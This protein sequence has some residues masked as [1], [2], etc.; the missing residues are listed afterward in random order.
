MNSIFVTGTDTE[1]GKTV[2]STALLQALTARGLSTLA[3]KPVAA[4][5]EWQTA[6]GSNGE[7][8]APR[9]CNEDA[10]ALNAAASQMLPYDLLNPYAL[11][12]AIAPHIAAR[13]E[14]REI[15]LD[16]LLTSL[17]RIQQYRAD[18]VVIEGAGG[19]QLPLND[20]GL[21]MP[22]FVQASGAGVVLV[23]GLQLGCLNHAL[24][25]AAAIVA[26]GCT[27]RGWIGVNN[28]P[29]R[30]ARQAE[31]IDYLRQHL[32]APCLGILPYVDNWQQHNLGQYLTVDALLPEP[33]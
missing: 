26:D 11:Q 29:Q 16:R 12:A 25:S 10:L 6:A 15:E 28:Q 33:A 1:V 27:L 31:N 7:A 3:M 21:R 4:G 23:V 8:Q 5:C 32:A 24:L 9:W 17:Q 19:W 13:E 14:Q 20:Q 22:S 30:M 18:Y 2:A